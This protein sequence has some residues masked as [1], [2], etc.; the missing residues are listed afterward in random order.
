LSN[1]KNKKQ[2]VK[3][4]LTSPGIQSNNNALVK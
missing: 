1:K 4:N 3:N 2:P